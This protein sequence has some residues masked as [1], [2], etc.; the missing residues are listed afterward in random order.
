MCREAVVYGW[1]NCSSCEKVWF[2]GHVY[3]CAPLSC[4]KQVPFGLHGS[5]FHVVI[6]QIPWVLLQTLTINISGQ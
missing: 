6:G 1:F 2:S 3:I 5:K 4:M